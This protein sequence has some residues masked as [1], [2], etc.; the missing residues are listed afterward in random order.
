MEVFF[1]CS[2]FVRWNYLRSIIEK[3]VAFKESVTLK[4]NFCIKKNGIKEGEKSHM[5]LLLMLIVPL[6]LVYLFS[7][8][9]K[10]EQE[11]MLGYLENGKIK[12]K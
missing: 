9:H 2:L 5:I 10:I 1:F 7:L 8:K 3:T 12:E 6:I 11:G 4:M